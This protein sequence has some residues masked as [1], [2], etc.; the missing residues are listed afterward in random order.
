MRLSGLFRTLKEK[1]YLSVTFTNSGNSSLLLFPLQLCH[2]V[3]I[4]RM[5]LFSLSLSKLQILILYIMCMHVSHTAQ[6]SFVCIHRTAAQQWRLLSQATPHKPTGIL[7]ISGSSAV[8]TY[9]VW[10]VLLG[11]HPTPPPSPLEY[12][13]WKLRQTVKCCQS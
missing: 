8:G 6:C 9:T 10:E 4:I 2:S 7:S 13:H 11:F 3:F 12:M 5:P 1:T